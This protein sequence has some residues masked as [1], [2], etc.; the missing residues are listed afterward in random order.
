MLFQGLI[1]I[2]KGEEKQKKKTLL[3]APAFISLSFYPTKPLSCRRTA[4]LVELPPGSLIGNKRVLWNSMGGWLRGIKVCACF[5]KFPGDR[6]PHPQKT[7][8]RSP[9][10]VF[11][12][13]G[14]AT[15][16]IITAAIHSAGARFITY[17]R[18][19]S[20]D[21]GSCFLPGY[22]WSRANTSCNFSMWKVTWNMLEKAC[23]TCSYWIS[24]VL[25]TM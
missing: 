4:D 15:E 13:D 18:T 14:L 21:A 19:G 25:W 2:K 6:S 24:L 10:I 12:S 23:S 3:E 22:S 9:Y 8:G 7:P 17:D 5:L 1:Q 20:Y 16:I 11:L